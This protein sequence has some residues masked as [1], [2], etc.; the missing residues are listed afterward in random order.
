MG[1]F[2]SYPS[3]F[4]IQIW[5]FFASGAYFDEIYNFI[6]E[7]FFL[8]VILN[9]GFFFLEK[10]FSFWGNLNLFS[11][12]L[13]NLN[14]IFYLESIPSFLYFIIP[15]ATGLYLVLSYLL[16]IYIW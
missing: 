5:I 8:R 3:F 6:I 15:L 10:N 7:N 1:T 2:F 14:K 11:F 4:K 16:I 13:V 12:I 9:F